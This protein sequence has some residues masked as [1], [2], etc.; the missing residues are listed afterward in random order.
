MMKRLLY[1]S[2]PLKNKR[3]PTLWKYSQDSKGEIQNFQIAYEG[4]FRSLGTISILRQHIF[5]LF[6][7]QPPTLSA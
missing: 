5:G 2:L 3:A 1:F 6:I 7:P 4:D